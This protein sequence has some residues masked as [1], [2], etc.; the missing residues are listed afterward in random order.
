MVETQT[1]PNST[2]FLGSSL[3]VQKGASLGTC[4]CVCVCVCVCVCGQSKLQSRANS[5][6]ALDIIILNVT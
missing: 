1:Q 5:V 6:S 2:G 4:Q 3:Q